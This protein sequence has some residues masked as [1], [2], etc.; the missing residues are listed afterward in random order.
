MQASLTDAALWHRIHFGFTITY[1]YLFPQLTMGLAWFLVYWKWRALRTG[2]EKYHRAA[3]FWARIFGLNFAVGVVT[4]I[5]M[6]FQFGTN[7]AGF[8]KYSGAV[9][10]QTLAMEGMFA[11]FLESAFIGALIWG[12]K[13]LGPRNHFLAAVGVATGS[14]LSGLFILLTNAFMQH[15]VGYAV[16]ANGTL[17]LADVG[18]FLL[19][20]W[21]LVQYAHNQCAALVTGSFAVA[22][23]GAF[24][25]LRGAHPEQAKVYLNTCTLVGLVASLL[26]AFPTGD[27][28]AKMVGR[29]QPVTLASME[30]LFQGTRLADV[31][32]IGQPNVSQ[33]RLENPIPLPGALSFLAYGTFQSYVRG[34]N[35]FPK[36]D[37]PDNIELIYYAF[38]IMIT[39][40]TIF[41][42]I[43]AWANWKRWRGR[44][45]SSCGLLWVLMLAFPFPYIATSLGWMTAEMGRQPW[46][47][48]GLFR[49]NSGY[50]QVVSAGDTIFTLIGFVGLYFVLGLL[51]LYLTGREI[52]KGPDAAGAVSK[53]Q[54]VSV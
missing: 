3:R 54:E 19:N 38:H 15:P 21:A 24:Y 52:H 23:M 50:S 13:R 16:A 35:E 49:T 5:P 4:G 43:M 46:L 45:E 6:E 25:T 51:F 26:V 2:D 22:A 41:I 29:Y 12:E 14:W 34:L 31:S 32:M 42:L 27:S 28:Q 48:Y 39:L 44:L 37:W 1:H 20:P 30:G 7:W 53:P 9:I 17:A 10:G 11:F 47:V 33:Q 40:G 8:S 18:A 36:E